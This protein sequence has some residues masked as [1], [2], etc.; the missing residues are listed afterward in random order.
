MSVRSG[1]VTFHDEVQ[2]KLVAIDAVRPHPENYNNGDVEKIMDS[3]TMNGMYRPVVVQKS[4][5]FVLAGNHTWMACKELGSEHI[6]VT[7]LD[8]DDIT[9]KKIIVADNE[10]ARQAKP[11]RGLL[12]SLLDDIKSHDSLIGTGFND[13]ELEALRALNDI[14][15]EDTSDHMQWPTLCFQIPPHA[16]KAF[17]DLTEQAGGDNERFAL[18]IRLAGWDGKR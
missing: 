6:P 15:A 2:D 17:Y 4:T 18:L 12:Q 3:I 10:I 8:V 7:Y 16:K 9:A 13:A 5:G 14:P 1:M 11:D